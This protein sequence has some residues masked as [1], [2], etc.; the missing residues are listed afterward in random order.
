MDGQSGVSRGYT[1]LELAEP[2]EPASVECAGRAPA[3]YGVQEPPTPAYEKKWYADTGLR[4]MTSGPPTAESG[5]VVYSF[6]TRSQRVAQGCS[7]LGLGLGVAPITVAPHGFLIVTIGGGLCL[8]LWVLGRLCRPYEVRLARSGELRFVSVMGVTELI[9]ADMR[10]ICG[11]SGG[12]MAHCTK[13]G[14]ST[15]RDPSL[16]MGTR[17]SLGGRASYDAVRQ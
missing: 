15:R 8:V 6:G 9:I 2:P 5:E 7:G 3:T 13:C 1:A 12:R 14:S 17:T 10:R 4:P 16:W 11:L